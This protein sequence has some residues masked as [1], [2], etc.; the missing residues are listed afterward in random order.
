[1]YYYLVNTIKINYQCSTVPPQ[2]LQADMQ[3]ISLSRVISYQ[4]I[5]KRLIFCTAYNPPRI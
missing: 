5:S 1:M 2:F 4:L 3:G